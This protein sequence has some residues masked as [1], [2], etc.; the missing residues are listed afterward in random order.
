MPHQVVLVMGVSGSGKTTVGEELAGRLGWPFLDADDLHPAAN[1]AKMAA[2]TP[3]TDAD[4]LPWLRR[5]AEWIA[6]R[7]EA[8]ESGVLGCSALK[9]AYRDQLRAADPGL[10]VVYLQGQRD[11]LA[12]RVSARHGHFFP[13]RL[14][15]AQL[16]DLEEPA[17]DEHAM[18]VSIGQ[19]PEKIVDSVVAA[20]PR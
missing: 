18:T 14:L 9:R 5:V 16:A 17:P 7:R 19:S 8:R 12:K 2:G 10:F 1:V 13:A 15:D 4:R 20:L 3:L 6:H 11:L